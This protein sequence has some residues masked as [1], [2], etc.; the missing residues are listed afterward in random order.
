MEGGVVMVMKEV[1]AEVEWAEL[2]H[3][4]RSAPE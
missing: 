3:L 2:I 1:F 4:R